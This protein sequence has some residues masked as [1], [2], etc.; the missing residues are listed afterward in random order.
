M[1]CPRP[2]P[3]LGGAGIE[4][5]GYLAGAD[6]WDLSS[7]RARTRESGSAPRFLG[8]SRSC[9]RT[10]SAH[11][12]GNPRLS[13]PSRGSTHNPTHTNEPGDGGNPPDPAGRNALAQNRLWGAP[14]STMEATSRGSTR[15]ISRDFRRKNFAESSPEF[16]L[17]M[18][19]LPALVPSIGDREPRDGGDGRIAGWQT[20]A[21]MSWP[22]A[23]RVARS[24]GRRGRSARTPRWRR[25]R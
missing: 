25:G 2:D 19:R 11:T 21:G 12:Q 17:L 5:G 1:Q 18:A 3:A 23:V 24:R 9:E 4:D 8:R 6:I 16:L 20:S 10:G 22:A 15:A 13:S 7:L 14:A